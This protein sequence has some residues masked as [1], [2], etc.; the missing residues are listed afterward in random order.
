M[1]NLVTLIVVMF[2]LAFIPAVSHA[3][4]LVGQSPDKKMMSSEK[5]PTGMAKPL[6]FQASGIVGRGVQNHEGQY[7]G[8][9]RDLMIDPHDGGVALAILSH[10][11]VLGISTKFVAAP[12]SAFTFN[13]AK[14][15]YVLDMS[16][17][18]LDAAPGFDRGQWPK[19]A[20]RAWETEVYRYYGETPV[21]G[22]SDMAMAAGHG[23]A[24]RF[25]EIRGT[26]V[27]NPQ[28]EKLGFIR[29]LVVDSEG[30]VPEA[31]LSHGGFLGIGTKWVAVSLND[32]QF[33]TAKHSFVL[34]W[35][36][37]R[38]DAAPAYNQ[39]KL[40]GPSWAERAYQDYGAYPM[41]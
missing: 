19:Y 9:I 20:D 24:Y 28:G 6:E 38:L 12:F 40:A 4:M 15:V 41:E 3:Q 18:K 8:V 1:K 16:R 31:V 37:E 2:A 36:K 5:D 14:G 29:D 13:P 26:T 17:E 30:H 27:R 34:A 35:T 23:S 21:W 22:D 32:L 25:T 7:L 39:S 10:G 11:G 33:D